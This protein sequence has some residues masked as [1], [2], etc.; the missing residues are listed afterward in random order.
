[1]YHTALL[2]VSFWEALFFLDVKIS[3]EFMKTACCERCG[4]RFFSA[5]DYVRKPRGFPEEINASIIDKCFGSRFSFR[6]GGCRKRITPPSV[7]FLG[8][9]IYIAPAIIWASRLIEQGNVASGIATALDQIRNEL[10][11]FLPAKTARRWMNWWRGA[12]WSSPF[13]RA[14]QGQLYGHIMQEKFLSGVWEHFLRSAGHVQ[15]EAVESLMHAV[16]TFFSPITHPP[17]YPF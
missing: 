8:R 10:Q 14:W 6:C 7:R 2:A 9:K 16:Q 11:D 5:S 13:W 4:C 15:T 12:V 1:M 17:V 3:D